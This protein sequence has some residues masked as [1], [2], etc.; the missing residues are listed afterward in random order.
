MIVTCVMAE[1]DLLLAT[2]EWE[3]AIKIYRAVIQLGE[4]CK[5]HGEAGL[6]KVN[7]E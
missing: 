6:L 5:G 1:G 3:K 2:K 4:Q 7:V